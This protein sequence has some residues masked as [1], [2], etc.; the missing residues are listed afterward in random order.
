MRLAC[1]LTGIAG[2]F[3]CAPDPNSVTAPGI[4]FHTDRFE[5]AVWSEPVNLGPLL[6]T[7]V[8]DANAF[9]ATDEHAI[10]FVSARP[11]GFGGNDLWVS[12][13]QCQTCPWEVPA[14]LGAPINTA[15]N[16]GAPTLSED[17]RLLFFFTTQA[18]GLGSA[19]IYVS[20]RLST[21]AGGEV[22]GEPVNLGADVN[23]VDTE[24]GS[25][26]VREGADRV[27]YFNR[28]PPG[29]SSDMHK[30]V[31]SPD[32]VP[33]GPAVAVPEFNTPFAD[34]KVS[35]RNDGLELF[36]SSTRP[37]SLGSFNVWTATRATPQEPWPALVP[38]DAPVNSNDIDSQPHLM[39]D[40]RTLIF[41]SSRPGGFG[42]NDLWMTTRR[43]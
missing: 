14:N 5:G 32:G 8:L 15:A 40:G 35:I 25:Y 6:N 34:Q 31:L 9:L 27:L 42:G 21:S 13:R 24:N 23:S 17:G 29:A 16:E 7:S 41:T 33:L 43:E 36:L 30:V 3:A 20:A 4:A 2:V 39:R 19:D 26:W 22:W 37:G 1:L 10:Y 18:D 38:L 11:G 12:R 28:V